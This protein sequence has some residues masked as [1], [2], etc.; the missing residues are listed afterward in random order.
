M[1]RRI[2]I[3]FVHATKCSISPRV[4]RTKWKVS[5]AGYFQSFFSPTSRVEAIEW[6]MKEDIYSIIYNANNALY[7]CV[8]HSPNKHGIERRQNPFKFLNSQR[9]HEILTNPAPTL[10]LIIIHMHADTCARPWHE[11]K[12]KKF[13]HFLS[14]AVVCALDSFGNLMQTRAYHILTCRL[15][16]MHDA[17]VI[18]WFHGI[19]IFAHSLHSTITRN[20]EWKKSPEMN[21]KKQTHFNSN[22]S[23]TVWWV[24][25]LIFGARSV[26]VSDK[27]RIHVSPKHSILM[28]KEKKKERKKFN[29]KRSRS[30]R[31]W[32]ARRAKRTKL[33]LKVFI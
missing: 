4:N 5:I 15:Q 11:M 1:R 31:G 13:V 8:P 14:V 24:Y 9:T 3:E 10:E 29:R 23:A 28:S 16:T 26:S 17:A 33:K 21:T 6:K 25:T 32:H 2:E 7:G 20:T 30:H 22:V 27:A 19:F 12:V 18:L